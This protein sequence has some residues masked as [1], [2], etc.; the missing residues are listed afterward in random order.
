LPQQIFIAQKFDFGIQFLFGN[1]RTGYVH[2]TGRCGGDHG[3]EAAAAQQNFEMRLIPWGEESKRHDGQHDQSEG[4]DHE[5]GPAEQS[6]GQVARG[7]R[8]IG[9]TYS[10]E[11][12]GHGFVSNASPSAR[13]S[14]EL[15]DGQFG[16]G[17]RSFAL[18]LKW[19]HIPTHGVGRNELAKF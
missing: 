6:G 17:L 1:F 11:S 9:D 3:I 2:A 5:P 18:E 15:I 10:C 7:Q 14:A 16:E 19:V 8:V 13:G 4:A 12:G